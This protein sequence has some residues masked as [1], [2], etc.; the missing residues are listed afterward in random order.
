M[1]ENKNI[2]PQENI[3]L[4]Q[5]Y[6][7]EKLV[8]LMSQI[9]AEKV[10][11]AALREAIRAKSLELAELLV[12]AQKN[13]VENKEEQISV[14]EKV[15]EVVSQVEETKASKNAH[16][17]EVEEIEIAVETS[18][19]PAP[20]TPKQKEKQGI[21]EVVK[22]AEKPTVEK[23]KA[24]PSTSA[25]EKHKAK[26]ELSTPTAETNAVVEV[27]RTATSKPNVWLISYSDGTSRESYIPPEKPKKTETTRV[28]PGGYDARGSR[29]TGGF[30]PQNGPSGRPPVGGAGRP[31]GG[32]GLAIPPQFPPKPSAQKGK[33]GGKQNENSKRFDDKTASKYT[34]VKRGYI[35][36][37]SRTLTDDEDPRWRTL[38]GGKQRGRQN[39]N[40]II[41]EHAIITTDPV[42]IKVLSEKIGKT[43]AEIMRTLLLLGIMKN[44]NGSIDF[45]TAEL[46]TAELSKDYPITL[47][48]RPETTYENEL[49]A[50]SAEYDEKN[51]DKLVG[52]PP[53]VTIMGHVDHGKT[54]L[55]D[56]I[57][58]ANVTGGE[59]GGIT[60]HIGAYTISLKGNPI[61]F[62]DT[63]GH[64][65]FTSMRARGAQVTDIAILV[66]AADDG[67]M[68]QTIEAINHAKQAGVPIIVACNKIDKIG[69]NPDRV[70]KQLTDYDL[71]PEEWGG[72]TPVIKVSAKTGDGVE[73]LLE[74]ILT[75]AE[76]NELRAI[77]AR[78]A[79]G[80]IIE[81]KMDKG[82]GKTATVLVQS[83][84]LKCGD[85]I[86]A[87]TST[88]RVKIMIDDKGKQVRKAGPSIP[89][90]VTGWDDLPE[91]GDI[92]DVVESDRFAR[93]LA[94][95]RKLL[96]SSK[97]GSEESSVNLEDLFDK[98][99][100][101]ELKC[102]NLIIKAD[103]QGS[104]EAVK[105][106]LA[107]LGNDEVNID[108]VHGGVGAINE[109]DVS[110]AD[111]A[112]AII[113]GF[114]VRP[115]ANAKLLAVQ[116]KIDI[117][118]YNIIYKAIEDI[119]AAVT[120]MLAPK[121]KEVVLGTAEVRELFKISGVG[122][123]AGCHVTD[124]K[125]VRG[126]KARLIRNGKVEVDTEISSLR[127]EK[128]DVK[129]IAKN[130]DC[131]IM[132]YNYNDIKS[133][134]IIEA[135][136]MEQI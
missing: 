20:E 67:I 22:Q 11:A 31:M 96:R 120:G 123:I 34:L 10:R 76:I 66:V 32:S 82:L 129:E 107:K 103:V 43:G 33:S 127:H 30:R 68:P 122:T 15:D 104:L 101:G 56:Y 109:S 5:A 47:E 87:G 69:A 65:A 136:K 54:S 119:Q 92:L 90:S 12:E 95:E 99:S 132:L 28:F 23:K 60:Q 118:F 113:I 13:A 35:V 131:G 26:G 73:T 97:K 53:V 86:I 70:L 111:T 14:P 44:I 19:E 128:E 72:E 51:A 124:G 1:S 98:I 48:F 102:V 112:H 71:L 83:G 46:V 4:M 17:A 114:N 29:P 121:F 7:N 116:K 80:T 21:Q 108:I 3:K 42:P 125:I 37:E 61:T 25:P 36:D 45:E 130:F 93:A 84:T 81:A 27:S 88:G 16:T 49:D 85:D 106:S 110:L 75:V 62:L 24:K 41:I 58:S 105:Q 6:K 50:R 78:P 126:V 115:D 64:E 39:S 2:N 133:G 77:A 100:K 79:R 94:E 18:P 63:P 40:A 89:V 134:D 91:A 57:R 55:L 9:S 74:N 38:K 117:R 59:A 52:R 135:Y 8:S